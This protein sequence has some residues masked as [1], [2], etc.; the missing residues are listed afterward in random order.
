[1]KPTQLIISIFLG[2]LG[3]TMIL[4]FDSSSK[5]TGIATIFI[6]MVL[7]GIGAAGAYMYFKR[8]HINRINK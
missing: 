6:G 1:M 2:L 8:K 3:I 7:I 5:I 4:H